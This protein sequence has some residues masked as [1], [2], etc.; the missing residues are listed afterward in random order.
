LI[1]SCSGCAELLQKA[2]EKVPIAPAPKRVESPEFIPIDIEEPKEPEKLIHLVRWPGETLS[3]IAKWYTGELDNWEDLAAANPDLNPHLLFINTKIC[4]PD[5]LI[6]NR[7]PMPKKFMSKFTKKEKK[8]AM[9]SRDTPLPTRKDNGLKQ[10]NDS[11]EKEDDST[12]KKDD[13]ILFGP[14]KYHKE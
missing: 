7:E 11:T 2:P 3:I 9:D 12:E 6:K 5:N 1:L 13:V 10:E 4:I 8:A 14:R